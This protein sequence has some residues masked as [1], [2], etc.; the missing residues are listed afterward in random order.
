[1]L[2][3]TATPHPN[4]IQAQKVKLFIGN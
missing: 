1:L 4:N 2:V 3:A